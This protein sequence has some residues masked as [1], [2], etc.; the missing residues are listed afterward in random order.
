MVKIE[1]EKWSKIRKII[2]EISLKYQ[3]TG[4]RTLGQLRVSKVLSSR[5]GG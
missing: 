3:D 2:K 1:N 5:W 4:L